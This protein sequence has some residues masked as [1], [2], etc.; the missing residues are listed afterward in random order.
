MIEI[1]IHGRGGGGGVTLAKLIAGAFFLRDSYVPAF[2][3]YGAERSGAPVQAY[4]RIDDPDIALHGSIARPDHVVIIDPS[5]ITSEAASGMKADG[6][7]IL[8]SPE[9][10]SQFASQFPGRRLATIDASVIAVA[11]QLGSTT[12]PIVNTTML[13]AVVK[14]LGLHFADVE[15]AL[16]LAKFG[17]PNPEAARAAFDGVR[18]QA[19][20]GTCAEPVPRASVAALGFF[21]SSAGS[22]PIIRTGE[23]ASRRPASRELAA[24]CSDACP[25]GNDVR[26]FLQ[27]AGCGSCAA[28][29]PRGAIV[30]EFDRMVVVR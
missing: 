20:A 8:N 9:D 19:A 24:R 21:D 3:V 14:L 29:C 23:W 18:T 27:A 1:A 17:G 11:N 2:G 15:A 13:G 30:M 10:P 5:L 28:R 16:A 26:G 6:W 12:P 7:V 4:V 25:A 22:P